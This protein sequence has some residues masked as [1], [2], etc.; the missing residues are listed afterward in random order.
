MNAK[1]KGCL[2]SFSLVLRVYLGLVFIAACW[3]KIMMPGEFALS[4]ATYDIV[5]L[6]WINLM[7]ILLPWIEL[8]VGLS[9]IL[10]WWTKASALCVIGMMVMFLVAL[11]IALSKGMQMSCGCFASAEAS[12]EIGIHTVWRDFFWLAGAVY[13]LVVDDGRWG[14]D[15]FFRKN[16]LP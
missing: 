2:L 5:P 10:G 8:F 15:G 6:S 3:Y 1:T 9:L 4:I 12:D 11:S 13:V 14:L 16:S 7:A